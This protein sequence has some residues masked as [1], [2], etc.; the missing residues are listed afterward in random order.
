MH[1]TMCTWWSLSL[2]KIWLESMQW[3]QLLCSRRRTWRD[4]SVTEPSVWK[5]DVNCW[6][7]VENIRV[8]ADI[9]WRVLL[10]LT[11]AHIGPPGLHY[12]VDLRIPNDTESVP[13]K[14][15][16]LATESPL[17]YGY[18]LQC[19]TC[20][21]YESIPHVGVQRFVQLILQVEHSKQIGRLFG[22]YNVTLFG[23]KS[24][25]NCRGT[26]RRALSVEILS[27]GA[28]IQ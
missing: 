1:P 20:V 25:Y 16:K 5:L 23:T 4:A 6:Y 11:E 22:R 2:S 8:S 10:I 18:F 14:Y 28:Q 13:L 15:A 24:S 9:L 21:T 3:F 26:A 27:T 19:N 17:I 12:S 7:V